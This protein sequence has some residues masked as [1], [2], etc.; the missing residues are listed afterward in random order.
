MQSYL[1]LVQAPHEVEAIKLMVRGRWYDTRTREFRNHLRVINESRAFYD[2]LMGQLGEGPAPVHSPVRRAEI[3]R[4]FASLIRRDRT[5]TA[6][7]T[8]AVGAGIRRGIRS[9]YAAATPAQRAL[10]V[11]RIVERAA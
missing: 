3:L 6:T 9:A 7:Q 1:E 4:T 8:A 11:R 2:G 10:L 5:L